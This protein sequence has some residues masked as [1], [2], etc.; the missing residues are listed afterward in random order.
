MTG[1]SADDRALSK[2]R[3]ARRRYKLRKSLAGGLISQDRY[4]AKLARLEAERSAEVKRQSAGATADTPGR[5]ADS[6]AQRSRYEYYSNL[7]ISMDRALEM[8]EISAPI[9]K[10]LV[11]DLKARVS[12]LD[13]LHAGRITRRERLD[14]MAVL[15]AQPSLRAEIALR[16]VRKAAEGGSP[17]ELAAAVDAARQRSPALAI[18]YNMAVGADSRRRAASNGAGA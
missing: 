6:A 18:A 9:H 3:Y 10:L 2:K 12:L 7:R 13:D 17:G 15:G 14:A 5:W 11:A 8:D 16:Q 4:E 1:C